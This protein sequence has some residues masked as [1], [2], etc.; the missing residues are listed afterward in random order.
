MLRQL[1]KWN[2]TMNRQPIECHG[3]GIDQ[4]SVN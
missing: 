2:G 4:F 1:W 3:Q